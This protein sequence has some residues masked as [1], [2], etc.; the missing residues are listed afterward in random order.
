[1]YG[2]RCTAASSVPLFGPYNQDDWHSPLAHAWVRMKSSRPSAPA[3][4]GRSTGRET[5]GSTAMSRSR[6]CP[7]RSRPTRTASP[8]SGAKRRLLAALNHQ[9]IAQIYGL[10]QAGGVHALAMELVA[11]EDLSERIARGAIPFDEALP[12]AR[13]IA[14]ALEA[15]HGLGIIHRD[16]KPANIKVRPDGTVKVLDFGLAKAMEPVFEAAGRIALADDY[17]AGR[18]SGRHH[19]RHGRLHESRAGPRQDARHSHRH[20]GVRLR[21]LRN[22]DRA[23]GVCG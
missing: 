17:D 13:Q 9:N 18:H 21:P 2:C 7:R 12:I 14:E 11:G 22:A 20:L 16:L 8:A 15:A 3:G 10:E 4:W 5:C 23:A 6:S 19:P 1:M